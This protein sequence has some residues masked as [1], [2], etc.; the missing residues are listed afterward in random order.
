MCTCTVM[1]TESVGTIILSKF[2]LYTL[3]S[4]EANIKLLQKLPTSLTLIEMHSVPQRLSLT[5]SKW[6]CAKEM[7]KQIIRM[8]FP[9]ASI[10]KLL[11]G[12]VE[13]RLISALN[14][15]EQ[16]TEEKLQGE[17]LVLKEHHSR[18]R[19]ANSARVYFT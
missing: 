10:S 13:G 11:K 7:L 18:F 14:F 5:K 8:L 12:R 15:M 6:D 9:S 2:S 19:A 17:K 16:I 3:C 1:H 4:N